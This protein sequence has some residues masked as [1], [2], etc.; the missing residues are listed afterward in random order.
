VPIGTACRCHADR[1]PVS[2]ASPSQCWWGRYRSPC[3]VGVGVSVAPVG[4]VSVGVSVAVLVGVGY[5]SPCWLAW[6]F[7]GRAW[8]RRSVPVVGVAVSVGVSVAVLVGSVSVAVPSVP[9]SVAVVVSCGVSSPWW[10]A[11]VGGRLVAVLVGVRVSVAGRCRCLSPCR[12]RRWR[13]VSGVGRT[14]KRH[15]AL[16]RQR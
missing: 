12:Q 6:R 5:R 16:I 2:V 8:C 14:R 15:G 1:R 3:V 4:G 10:S 11:G 13:R 7:G 9:A